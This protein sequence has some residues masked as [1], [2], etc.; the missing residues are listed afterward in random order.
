MDSVGF[1][2]V[3]S[4]WGTSDGRRTP[5]RLKANW[6]T[7]SMNGINVRHR[8]FIRLTLELNDQ[9]MINDTNSI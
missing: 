6:H 9:L 3:Q 7:I 8:N 4:D 5:D 2:L 1:G